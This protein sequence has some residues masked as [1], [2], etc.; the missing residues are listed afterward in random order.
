[1]KNLLNMMKKQE[2]KQNNITNFL[3]SEDMLKKSYKIKKSMD[4]LKKTS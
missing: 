4:I 1:M 2:E 3:I